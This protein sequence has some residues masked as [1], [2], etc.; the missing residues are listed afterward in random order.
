MPPCQHLFISDVLPAYTNMCLCVFFSTK[1]P[2]SVAPCQHCGCIS[3]QGNQFGSKGPRQSSLTVFVS[4]FVF[5]FCTTLI[6]FV[7]A[8]FTSGICI[9]IC[10]CHNVYVSVTSHRF[11]AAVLSIFCALLLP[12]AVICR[13]VICNCNL[14]QETTHCK[15]STTLHNSTSWGLQLPRITRITVAKKNSYQNHIQAYFLYNSRRGTK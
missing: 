15:F 7:F 6:V 11:G 8:F 3:N 9:C 14:W 2:G 10:I 1:E 4:G 12:S 5:R 13:D